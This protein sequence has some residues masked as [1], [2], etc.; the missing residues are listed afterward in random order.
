MPRPR[1]PHFDHLSAFQIFLIERGSS[2][3]TAVQYAARIGA[4]L[5]QYV[6]DIHD[7]EPLQRYIEGPT[8]EPKVVAARTAWKHFKVFLR[9]VLHVAVA[10]P[11]PFSTA[12]LKGVP[13]TDAVRDATV[14]EQFPIEP[15]AI[16][17][18]KMPYV[19]TRTF[20]ALTWDAV[21]NM[22]GG[23]VCI[24]TR[25]EN[26]APV[27][28]QL[29]PK[30]IAAVTALGQ[31]HVAMGHTTALKTPLFPR[32]R[33]S[34]LPVTARQMT[35]RLNDYWISNPDEAPPGFGV[36]TYA[37]Q[38]NTEAEVAKME[39]FARAKYEQKDETLRAN[40]LQPEIMLR[41]DIEAYLD[42][43]SERNRLYNET[44]REQLSLVSAGIE[45]DYKALRQSV[46]HLG[47]L[48]APRI[49]QPEVRAMVDRILAERDARG[50]PRPEAQLRMP[51]P[52]GN[53]TGLPAEADNPFA[54]QLSS[55]NSAGPNVNSNG[56]NSGRT[57]VEDKDAPLLIFGGVEDVGNN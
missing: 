1:S 23:T 22:A 42:W 45:F 27:R 48:E 55:A 43:E 52:F 49:R 56:A 9:T 19:T 5:N 41:A 14:A 29:A 39:A 16:L 11:E 36:P 54:V 57:S 34:P 4:L 47:H 13:L 12:L 18:A 15:A 35:M 53:D 8:N 6:R 50:I 10:E 31:W 20:A 17:R 32:H 21:K 24:A 25:A 51:N 37:F 44:M 2:G 3:A 33:G 46:E 26:G 30:E 7:I 28:V 38:R 40:L